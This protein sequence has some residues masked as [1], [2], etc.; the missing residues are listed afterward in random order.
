MD[1]FNALDLAEPLL[2]ALDDLGHKTPTPIQA[3][4]I[5]PALQGRDVACAIMDATFRICL[6]PVSMAVNR[7][8]NRLKN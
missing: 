1:N 4:A 3:Q 7:L 6:S 2:R 5:P 8:R